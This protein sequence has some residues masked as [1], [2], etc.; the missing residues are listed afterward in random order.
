MMLSST[1]K[2]NKRK[3]NNLIGQT[4]T[5]SVLQ[6]TKSPSNIQNSS[7]NKNQ[8]VQ[9]VPLQKQASGKQP[10]ITCG[11]YKTTINSLSQNVHLLN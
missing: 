3:N 4:T 8:Q 6:S 11:S 5:I 9:L 2:F 7:T 10:T 1:T